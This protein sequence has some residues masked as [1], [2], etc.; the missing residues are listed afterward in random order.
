MFIVVA[1]AVPASAQMIEVTYDDGRSPESIRAF[2]LQDD[3]GW[4]LRA[5]DVARIFRATQ[6]WNATARK[7][8][9]GVGDVRFTVTVDTRVV[10]VRGEPLLMQVP[11]RY[12]AG[13]V[14]IPLEFV[15]DIVANYTPQDFLWDGDDM[16]LTVSGLGFNVSAIDFSS[17]KDRT[18]VTIDLSEPLLYNLDSST[19]GVIRLKLY[20]GRVDTRK[21]AVREQRGL[22]GGVRADQTDRDA[23][24]Y[25]D[26]SRDMR[27]VNVDREEDPPR[28]I[29]ALE[30]GELPD[31]PDPAFGDEQPVEI[32]D[33]SQVTRREIEIRRVVIDP[34]HGGQDTGKVGASGTAEKDVNLR[35]A[36]IA[37]DKLEDELGVDVVLTREQDEL[38]S[39]TKRTEIAN[40][41]GADVF[42]SLHCNSWFSARTGGFEA[43]FLSPARSES[44]RQLQRFENQ[45]AAVARTTPNNDIDF[46][47]W[48]L[49]Q[50]EFIS[51][52]STLAEMVQR[53][54]IERLGIR[55]RGVK[56]ANFVVLQGARMPSILIE[57][58]FLS[59]PDE[60]A[61]L[62]DAAFLSEVADGLVAA[63]RA[64][65][66]RYR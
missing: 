50:N 56:Q 8:V 3:P 9:L 53:E 51:E 15:T 5:N 36:K 61:K 2:T 39:L 20:G 57:T 19:P 13:F 6:F 42:I 35:L 31:I 40:E 29:L 55:N 25:F 52:S 27:R 41:V 46:I 38:I 45:D 14:M 4:Y 12:D 47:V 28:L 10:V 62:N 22:V 54:M 49:A 26:V 23:L 65:Q 1:A 59:N 60:E 18:T 58:A 48:E 16:T 44:D 21:F 43:Y 30:R 66:E 17:T 11:V 63:L 24:L 7:I 34:G 37:R 32:V 33:R 64:F